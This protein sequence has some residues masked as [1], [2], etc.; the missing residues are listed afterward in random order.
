[1]EKNN[2]R[3]FSFI[4]ILVVVAIIAILASI[5]IPTYARI[6]E[7][8][9]RAVA[10]DNAQSIV[11]CINAHNRA[12]TADDSLVPITGLMSGEYI[13]LSGTDNNGNAVADIDSI[14][15]FNTCCENKISLMTEEDYDVAVE[16]ITLLYP[17]DE[18]SVKQDYDHT[19]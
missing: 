7:R 12:A 17:D 6:Q 4:E 1:M 16:Y 11:S 13:V 2:N 3:G 14:E 5:S 19:S 15:K 8:A 18:F 10:I 9:N